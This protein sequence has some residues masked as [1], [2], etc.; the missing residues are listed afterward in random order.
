MDAISNNYTKRIPVEGALGEIP[1]IA[2]R[3]THST[4]NQYNKRNSQ[5][6][7]V[8]SESMRSGRHRN[9]S[10]G[11]RQSSVSS[12]RSC[13]HYLPEKVQIF[14]KQMKQNYTLVHELINIQTEFNRISELSFKD[15]RDYFQDR[16]AEKKH[17][18]ISF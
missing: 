4:R 8:E 16:M 18:K 5:N 11:S 1:H 15:R 6:I 14:N 3:D 10:I 9:T 17:L 7:S 13:S 12:N 2:D